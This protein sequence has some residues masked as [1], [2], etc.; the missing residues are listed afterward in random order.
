MYPVLFY[1]GKAPVYAYS[2]FN[3]L[4]IIVGAG[5]YFRL[6]GSDPMPPEKRV[7][8]W[9]AALTGGFIGAK[10][11]DFILDYRYIIDNL[12]PYLRQEIGARTV[13]GGVIGGY[14][15]VRLAK[16]FMGIK[17]KTGDPFA[18]SAIMAMGIGRIGCFFGGCC[19]GKPAEGWHTVYMAGQYRYPTQLMEAG[20]DFILFAVL[21]SL[22]GRM[23]YPGDLFKLFVLC[24][25]TFRFFIEFIRTEPVKWHGLTIYQLMAVPLIMAAGLYFY[26]RYFRQRRGAVYETGK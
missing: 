22:R 13:L 4:A 6:T 17:K 12:A 1:L 16:N 10:L 3:G 24:Y 19:Y 23:K 21:W 2:F 26:N 18:L 7:I 8:L 5:L 15:G 9:T 25:A 11:P 20:F 14:F